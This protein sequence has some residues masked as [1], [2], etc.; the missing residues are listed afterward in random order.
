M[1]SEWTP[2][3]VQI[4]LRRHAATLLDLS[5]ETPGGPAVVE[6]VAPSDWLDDGA[7]DRRGWVGM[8]GWYY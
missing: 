1:A 5:N 4:G 2:D 8:H 7:D 3:R 6:P